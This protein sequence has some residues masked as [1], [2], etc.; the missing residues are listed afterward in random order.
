MHRAL[1]G[2]MHVAEGADADGGGGGLAARGPSALKLIESTTQWLNVLCAAPALRSLVCALL[3]SVPGTLDNVG[4]V[5]EVTE[6][7][8]MSSSDGEHR[9]LEQGS[10]LQ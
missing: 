5:G 9:N 3:M 8:K 7:G 4:R 6:G 10:P 1:I 2:R